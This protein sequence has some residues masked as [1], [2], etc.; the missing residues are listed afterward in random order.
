MP[1]K[2]GGRWVSDHDRRFVPADRRQ[3]MTTIDRGP[4]APAAPI[5]KPPVLEATG[6]TKHFRVRSAGRT[7]VVQA[8]EDIDLSLVPGRIVALVGESGSGK[9]TLARLLARFYPLTDGTI[10]LRGISVSGRPDKEYFRSVQL[11]FQDPFGSLHPSHKISYNLERPLRIHGHAKGRADA[12]RQATELL[13]RVGLTP[14]EDYL[15]KLPYEL[16]GGQR[17]RVVIARALAVR[18]AVLLG[19]EP[20]SMLDV[21]IRLDMLNLLARLRDEEGLALLYITHDIASAR[22]LCDDVAVMY[23]G[24]MIESGPKDAVIQRPMHPYTKLLVEASPDPSRTHAAEFDDLDD[25]DVPDEPPSLVDPPAG[26]RFHP[27]CPFA[28]DECRR[29]L[30]ERTDLGDGHWARCWLHQKGRAG[31]L[32]GP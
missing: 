22:Y 19:D 5:R 2:L 7:D 21:S 4:A 30:P 17:Q 29:Q 9:T 14:A 23:A 20:I 32:L 12:R 28:M 15:D 3:P 31:E 27:R 13:E 25:D 26:C 6:V 11:I 8:V 16:S 18:P 1:M 10:R 24:Q